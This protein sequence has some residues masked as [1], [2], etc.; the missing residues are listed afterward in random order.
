MINTLW[1]T[2]VGTE[3][4]DARV[5]GVPKVTCDP[6]DYPHSSTP[7]HSMPR[8][9]SS[10]LNARDSVIRTSL[11]TDQSLVGASTPQR[12]AGVLGW[13]AV[14]GAWGTRGRASLR[15]GTTLRGYL[16]A[17]HASSSSLEKWEHEL[18]PTSPDREVLVINYITSVKHAP[19]GGE[20]H[21]GRAAIKTQRNRLSSAWSSWLSFSSRHSPA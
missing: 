20:G 1:E 5:Q 14:K 8:P 4:G 10:I 9:L 17:A 6:P 3:E 12:W 21:L 19:L 2:F 11:S 16:R 18:P 15:A 13:G 7:K